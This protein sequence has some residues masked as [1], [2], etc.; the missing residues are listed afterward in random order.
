MVHPLQGQLLLEV[1]EL[2]QDRVA[3]SA[4]MVVHL[5][6]KLAYLGEKLA[7]LGEKLA[8]LGEK[9]AFLLAVLV[10][11]QNDFAM[12][13]VKKVL[14]TEMVVHLVVF[15]A[16]EKM[17]P[18]VMVTCQSGLQELLAATWVLHFFLTLPSNL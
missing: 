10:A 18:V 11:H 12:L 8:H 15:Q 3:L 17:L 13:L 2:F 5:G 14:L 16:V 7:Y 9:L 1:F 4:G 6:E